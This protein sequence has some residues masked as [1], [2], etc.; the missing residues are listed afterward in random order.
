MGNELV[1]PNIVGSFLQGRQVVQQQRESEQQNQLRAMQLQHA[2]QAQERDT[3]F[4]SALPAYLQG[5]TNGLAALYTADPERAMQAQSFMTQQNQLAQ[6]QKVN[7]AKQAF[8]QAQGVIN[9]EAP[10]TYMRLLIPQVAQQWAEHSGKSA[11]EMTDEEAMRLAT[12]VSTLAGAQA[13]ILPEKGEAFTLSQGQTRFDAKGKPVASV[14]TPLESE[15][16]AKRQQTIFERANTLRD[17]YDTQSKDFR[18]ASDA[19]QR[20]LSSAQNPSAAGDLAL[21][22]SYMRTLDPASSV[23]E[24]EFAN[25][26]NAGSVPSRIRSQYNKVL[27]GERLSTEQRKDFVTKAGEL[28][29]GQRSIEEKRRQKYSALAT[30]A[31]ADPLDVVGEPVTIDVPV[32]VLGVGQSTTSNGFTIKR[33]K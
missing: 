2:Q 32:D 3:Q 7:Q 28:Y 5:G 1:M 31:G 17:E 29:Q 20:V 11:D 19:Y 26:E 10:A 30:R 27:S 21:I 18:G 23:R 12:Q 15:D 14:K 22:F 4:R 13:G 16:P 33:K 6:T 24:G 8:A 9:S 25:A